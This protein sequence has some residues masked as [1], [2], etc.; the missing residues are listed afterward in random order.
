MASAGMGFH[1]LHG[2]D[3]ARLRQQLV[4]SKDGEV[5]P[6][7]EA[8]KGYEFERDHYVT[9]TDKELK[10]LDEKA[11]QGI[12]IT[13]FV[14]L[15]SVDPVYFERSYYLAPDKGGDKAF[16]LLCRAVEELKLAAVGQYAARGKD[17]LVTLRPNEGHLIMHQMLHADEIRPIQE[18]PAADASVKPA[19]LKLAR[20]LVNQLAAERF[21]PAKYQDRVRSRVRNL[22]AERVEGREVTESPE[23]RPR[24][25]VIDL[26]E[27]LKASLERRGT[28]GG[29][30]A[31]RNPPRRAPTTS[32]A[33]RIRKAR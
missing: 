14:P 24:A 19:E 28:A 31:A 11:T 21:E 7:S 16:A 18:V 2:K 3:G 29:K 9:F 12:E 6:R 32:H 26:M 30:T 17:Y 4:C 1:L 5:V 10:E 33:T 15:S 8:I 22:I 13:E 27:A 23:A 25:Q 20:D